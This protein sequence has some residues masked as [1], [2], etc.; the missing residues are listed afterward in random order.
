VQLPSGAG[1]F[2]AAPVMATI[3]F[4]SLR[5]RQAVVSAARSTQDEPSGIALTSASGGA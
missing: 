4:L 3:T 2:A 1:R 5:S